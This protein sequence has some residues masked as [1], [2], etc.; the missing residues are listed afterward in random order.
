MKNACRALVLLA[1]AAASGA[2]WSS[3]LAP[4][5]A[6]AL[7]SPSAGRIERFDVPGDATVPGRAV[8]VWLPPDYPAKAPYAVVLMFDGQMLFDA[9]TTWN[10]QEWRADETA[11]AV[12]AAGRT[13][14]FVIVAVP[15]AGPARHAEYFPQKPYA[16]LSPT[17][18]GLL[19]LGRRLDGSKL[20]AREVYSDA[21]AAWL[22]AAVLPAVEARVALRPGAADRM[23]IGSSMGGLMAMYTV[24]EHPA[25]F[26]GFGALSTHWPGV[27]DVIGNPIPDAFNAYLQAALPAPGR[28]RLYFDHGDATL[29]AAYP[30]LQAEVDRLAAARGWRAPDWRSTAFPGAEHSEAA[31]AARLDGVFAFL[32]PPDAATTTVSPA[33]R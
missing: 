10:R 19:D 25:A 6:G 7:P 5:P 28:H 4:L 11:A 33:G 1:L 18:R 26:G 32:L 2:A 13:R 14:P 9:S 15:N 30:P 22:V 23:V 24:L 29:D 8:D 31:W 16:S 12:Q 20:F 17:F 27:F 3:A 21:F